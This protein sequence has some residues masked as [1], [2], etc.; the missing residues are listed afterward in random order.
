MRSLAW[1]SRT[2]VFADFITAARAFLNFCECRRSFRHTFF[3][4]F[5]ISKNNIQSLRCDSCSAVCTSLKGCL[6]AVPDKNHFLQDWSR[7]WVLIGAVIGYRSGLNRVQSFT[8]QTT[9][10]AFFNFHLVLLFSP[11]GRIPLYCVIYTQSIKTHKHTCTVLR[12]SLFFFWTLH[13]QRL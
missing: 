3:F 2:I 11:G 4:F 12:N 1:T 8:F 5:F 13:R 7:D 10:L 9:L 6:E